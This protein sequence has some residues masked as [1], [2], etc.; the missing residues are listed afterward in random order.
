MNEN[1][2]RKCDRCEKLILHDDNP[3]LPVYLCRKC[4]ALRRNKD[5]T[6]INN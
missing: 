1:K 6:E 3:E 5:G 4:V 2:L